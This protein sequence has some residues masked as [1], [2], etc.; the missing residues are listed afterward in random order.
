MRTLSLPSMSL[1]ALALCAMFSSLA[2]RAQAGTAAPA[3]QACSAL[4][5][6]HLMGG[7][8]ATAHFE[9]A[10]PGVPATG[11]TPARPARPDNCVVGGLLNKRVGSDGAPYAIRFELRLPAHWSGRF[12]Y[13]GGGGVDGFLPPADG[14]YPSGDGAHSALLDGMAVV[15]TDSG[16][17]AIPK[18]PNGAFLFGAEPQ[19]RDEYGDQQLPLVAGSAKKL[20]AAFYNRPAQWSYFY[21]C[22]NGGR[23]AMVAAQRAPDLFDGIIACSPGFRLAQAAIQ[24]S[25][26]RAQLAATIAPRKADGRPDIEH[27]LSADMQSRIGRAML[28]DC[29]ALDGLKDGMVSH[30]SACRFKPENWACSLKPAADCLSPEVIAFVSAYLDGGRLKNG[31]RIY[32]S[33]PADPQ[34]VQY[35]GSEPE[36]YVALFAGE[37]SHVY[38]TPPTVTPDLI[39][40]ALTSDASAEYAKLFAT[41]AHFR[42]SGAAL[43]NADSPDMDAFHRHGGKLLLYTGTADWAFPSTDAEAYLAQVQQRYGTDDTAGFFRLFVIP[44]MLHGPS[45][46]ATDQF[47]AMGAMIAWVEQG[48]APD[49]LTAQGRKTSAWP[50]RGRPLC[51]Y[52]RE[53]TYTGHGDPET[54]VNFECR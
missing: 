17:E 28:A 10:T 13:M 23:Q 2:T 24:G 54:A 36:A 31:Q 14:T 49:R 27:A 16:H 44:G 47:N 38:T 30:P 6:T 29:D 50:G 39:G 52:P 18:L 9:T 33:V 15:V 32:S 25:I 37:A 19:A 41:D 26:V 35:M 21:G 8:V 51:A 5:A 4:T 43:T 53:A 45:P 1:A 42:R 34:V 3:A 20:I 12:L 46:R 48:S 11:T 7:N 40:Y 22:S